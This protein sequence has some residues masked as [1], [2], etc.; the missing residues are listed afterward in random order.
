M[1]DAA[2]SFLH[3][4]MLA[5]FLAAHRHVDLDIAVSNAPADIVAAGYDAGIQLGEVIDRDMIA[6]PISGDLRL[7]VVASAS[8][9]ARR[10]RPRHPRD[11]AEHD[12]LNWHPTP[13]APAYRWE[14]TEKGRDFSVA[15][16]ARVLTTDPTLLLS[17]ARA[18]AG[19]AMLFEGQARDDVAKGDLVPVLEEFSEPFSGFYL[20]YPQRRQASP[21]LRALIDH[22]R[23]TRQRKA[24]AKPV[25]RAPRRRTSARRG[26][27]SGG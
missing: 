24:S 14:F 1:A 7:V 9:L 17:L 3:G 4:P 8:Y 15:V 5:S 11:L 6:V 21:A 13:D 10:G 19:L 23:G 22:L 26:G 2:E 18:G 25:S 12:V 27:S 16:R 20:Y